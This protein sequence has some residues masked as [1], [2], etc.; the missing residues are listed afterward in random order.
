MIRPVIPFFAKGGVMN[1][2]EALE[3]FIEIYKP[4]SEE[5]HTLLT[6][7]DD[8]AMFTEIQRMKEGV[9]M[10]NFYEELNKDFKSFTQCSWRT[11]PGPPSENI[12]K[13]IF[14]D[15]GVIKVRTK[16]GN[17]F[18]INGPNIYWEIMEDEE[19]DAKNNS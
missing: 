18:T 15:I 10:K 17:I 7:E 16:G 4:R 2:K 19:I 6:Q 5:G 1:G 12:K 13:I 3:L 9:E 11:W 14:K 8:A